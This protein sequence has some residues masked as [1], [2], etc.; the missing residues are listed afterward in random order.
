MDKHVALSSVSKQADQIP[1][2]L[3][4]RIDEAVTHLPANAKILDVGCGSGKPIAA[5]LVDK[6]FDVYGLD[7]SPKQIE[8]AKK[9]I[10]EDHLFVGDIGDFLTAIKFDAIICWFTLFHVHADYHLEILKKL[11]HLLV[12][13]G[14]LLISFA[15]TSYKAEG[16]DLK[17]IDEYTIE[18][19]MFGERFYHSGNPAPFNSRLVILADFTILE[20]KIDQPGNQVI[21]ARKN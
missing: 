19:T 17:I 6:G 7:I 1:A 8:Y 21:L 5:Y 20:D 18:S 10:P 2:D 3:L 13:E 12:P 9:V 11:N 4:L 16:T 14:I 15:D